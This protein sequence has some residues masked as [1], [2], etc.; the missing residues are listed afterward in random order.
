MKVLIVE[1]EVKLAIAL[2]RGLTL[3][4]YTADVVH[5]GQLALDRI[6]AREAEYDIMILDLM[7]PKV[8][9]AEVCLTLRERGIAIP[10][11]VLTAKETTE[12]KVNLLTIGADDYLVK[13]FAFAE[14]V[15]RMKAIL[16]R[17]A[18]VEAESLR[19]GPIVIDTA[20]RVVTAGNAVLNLTRKEYAILECLIRH[21]GVVVHREKLLSKLWDDNFDAGSNVLDVHVK[22]IRKKLHAANVENVLQTVRG[23]G[24]RI[25]L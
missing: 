10:I 19:V 21:H 2:A 22:N 24:Y 23:V 1:D 4:G 14:L 20:T 5:D 3:K 9:G 11:L 13:P 15:A 8:D 6:L 7:L 12:N 17:P 18:V 25:C 16:R